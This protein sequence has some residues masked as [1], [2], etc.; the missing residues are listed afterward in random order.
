MQSRRSFIQTLAAAP[1][2]AAASPVLI[3][4]QTNSFSDRPLDGAIRAMV[5]LGIKECEL[6]QGHVEMGVKDAKAWRARTPASHFRGIAR[7]LGDAGIDLRI[8]DFQF[9]E[10]FTDTEIER[11][12]DIA[13]ELGAKCMVTSSATV[14]LARRIAPLAEKHRMVVGMHGRTNLTDPNQFARPESYEAAIA[15]SP[16][17]AINLD[18]G[19]FTAAGFDAVPFIEKHHERIV[20]LHLKDRKRN[21]G[22]S[23]AFGE[24]DSPIRE[25]LRLLG[26]TG[27]KIPAHIEHDRGGDRVAEF[28]RSYDYC[29][30][31]LA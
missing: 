3:G 23:M 20:S 29:L 6:W 17:V 13:H 7:K 4:A 10:D 5:E 16:W 30:R 22:P 28:R 24:G 21:Q 25:T 18:L 11:G 27:W 14:P 12:L 8:Y 2:L 31:A 9:H 19:H 26:R 1:A 15:M